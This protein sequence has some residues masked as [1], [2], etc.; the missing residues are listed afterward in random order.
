MHRLIPAVCVLAGQLA[1]GV[2]QSPAP[3]DATRQ[4]I[5]LEA[6]S[7][8]KGLDLEANPALK[9]VVLKV[10]EQVRGTPQFVE[11]VRDFRIKGQDQALLEIALRDPAAPAGTAAIRQLVNDQRFDLL[12]SA[13]GSTN[14][15]G[16]A[17]GLGNT[18]D[19]AIV[20]LLEPVVAD[21]GLDLT[22][23]KQAV[24][25]LA[26]VAEGAGA[27]L[28]L[29]SKQKLPDDLRLTT[30]SELNSVRWENLRAQAA[31]VLP[32]PRS[33]EPG[34]LPP[35]TELLK[36]SGNPTNG[37]A[38]FRRE[39]VGCLK[40]HQLNGEGVDFGPSLLEIGAKLAKQAIYESILDPSAGIAFGY[41]AWQFE[42]KDGG[43]AYGLVVS[44]TA[45]EVAVKAV[46]G[47][48]TRY[49]KGDIVKRTKQKLSIMPS[50][51]EQAMSSQELVDLV[52]YLSSLKKA[53]R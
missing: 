35:I 32:M 14:A 2:E 22:L 36:L 49:Q 38:V 6:L 45:D 26:K 12:K 10:L 47:L 15:A 13:L 44:E 31:R 4:S 9:A 25:A 30:S 3:S 1:L 24:R 52:E 18:G 34:P 16:I 42:L 37:A 50:G 46:G 48:V 11:L 7:R 43:E 41:E 40:C 53:G 5:N 51:L 23:R 21:P 17:Q 28:E 29:A 27:L 19:K 39:T 33:R 8:L 20:P